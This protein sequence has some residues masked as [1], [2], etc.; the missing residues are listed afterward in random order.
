MS[1]KIWKIQDL[2]GKILN[3]PNLAGKILNFPNLAGKILNFPNL[4]G[5]IWNFPNVAI[6][7]FAVRVE[8]NN[9]KRTY[10]QQL[11]SSAIGMKPVWLKNLREKKHQVRERK[12]S[13][14]E[15][16]QSKKAS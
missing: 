16:L 13:G 1:C 12:M 9:G 5:K 2:A 14:T 11:T 4:A 15:T 3:F 7:S 10:A 8:M 6:F